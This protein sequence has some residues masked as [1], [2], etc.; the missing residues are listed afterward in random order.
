MEEESAFHY[1]HIL[2]LDLHGNDP[3]IAKH[4]ENEF[5]GKILKCSAKK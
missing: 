2:K 4:K 3:W 1:Q 5:H